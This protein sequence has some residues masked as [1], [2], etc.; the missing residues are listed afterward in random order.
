MQFYLSFSHFLILLS[1]S[2]RKIFCW[3]IKLDF[4]FVIHTLWYESNAFIF[5]W[6]ASVAMLISGAPVTLRSLTMPALV[7]AP[8]TCQVV[9]CVKPNDCVAMFNLDQ[10]TMFKYWSLFR[11]PFFSIYAYVL[12]CPQSTGESSKQLNEG[13]S[14]LWQLAK[15]GT[16]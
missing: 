10:N 8:A 9:S 3:A 13:D 5:G 7:I 2:G 4:H 15:A 14:K 1:L 6:R 12:S 11:P 16:P